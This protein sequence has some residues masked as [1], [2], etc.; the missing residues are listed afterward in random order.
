[1]ILGIGIDLVEPQ[2]IA[3]LRDKYG[4][5]FARRVLTP[6]EWPG[7]LR[8]ARPVLFLANRFAAKEAFS[9]AMG[10]GFRYPVTLQCISVVQERSGKPGFAFHPNLEKLVLSRGIVRHHLT[11][12][13]EM[14]L[15]CACVVLEAE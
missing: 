1:M 3:R 11:I 4:E 9:K 12:S 6:L 13:D 8:T 14:S 10:T 7:Y 15:A 5:R 2:R